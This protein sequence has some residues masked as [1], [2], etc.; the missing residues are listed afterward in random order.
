MIVKRWIDGATA[1]RE[2]WDAIDAKLA[3]RGWMSLN[4]LTT[5]R[6]RVAEKDGEIVGLFVLQL[7]PQ[8]GP[9][10]VAPRERGSG[11]ADDLANEMLD[12]LIE[13]QARGWFIVA[14]SPHVPKMC[15]DR[16]LRKLESPIY[17]S[18]V[19]SGS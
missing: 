5:P 10:W 6:I 15:E 17:T 16:G 13:S 7:T 1:S 8:C 18:E 3:A 14:D 12:F 19:T 2:D 4:R 11:L 9:M